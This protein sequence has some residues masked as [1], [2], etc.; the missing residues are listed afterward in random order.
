MLRRSAECPMPTPGRCSP[1]RV[2]A[3]SA[4]P[5]SLAALAQGGVVAAGIGLLAAVLL[6]IGLSVVGA[7][8]PAYR[9][10]KLSVTDALRREGTA[11]ELV[12]RLQRMRKDAGL[13]VAGTKKRQPASAP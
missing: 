6:A 4:P 8:I 10:S 11:R 3:P 7:L 2:C 5:K 9:A 12:S 1:L 13:A